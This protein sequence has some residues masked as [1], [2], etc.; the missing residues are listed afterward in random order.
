M[1]VSSSVRYCKTLS[2][3]VATRYFLKEKG[4]T[5]LFYLQAQIRTV[6]QMKKIMLQKKK[7][8]NKKRSGLGNV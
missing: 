2:R 6:C 8:R 1:I 5:N 7:K 3:V 4:N